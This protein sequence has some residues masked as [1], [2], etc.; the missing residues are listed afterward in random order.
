M[1]AGLASGA[2][3]AGYRIE[4]IVGR[5]G[6]G[7][8]Y[9]A[10]DLSLERPVALKLIAPELA[11][12]DQFRRR[13]LKEPKLAAALDHPNVVP[14]YEAGEHDGQ[15]YLAMR[16]V[17]GSDMRTLLRADGDLAPERALDILAQVASA[18]DAAHRRGL[19]HRDVKPA[20]VLIDED[21]HVYLTDFGVTKQLGGDSTESGQLVGTL[22]YLAPEQIRGEDVD[23]RADLY[24]LACVLYQCLAGHAPFHRETEAETLWAHM[25][26]RP[27]PLAEH[28]DLD[29]VIEKALAKDREDRHATCA[30][31]IEDA[32]ATLT[33]PRVPP[34][35]L[36]RRHAILAAGLLVLAATAVA[37]LLATRDGGSPRP[38]PP[39]P[40][41]GNGLARIG[42]DGSR[43]A[44]FT[45]AGTPPSN[46]AVGEGSVW[47]L[48][49][50]DETVSRVDPRT[51]EVIR[52]FEPRGRPTDI[53]AGAGALWIGT[54]PGHT[55]RVSRVDPATMRE[56]HTE[57]MPA[58]EG[59]VSEGFPMIAV[60][61]GAVWAIN[62]DATVSRL[63]ARTGRRVAT[64]AAPPTGARTIAAGDG[65]VWVLGWENALTRIDP[66]TNRLGDP[67]ELGSNRLFGIAVGAGAAWATSEEGVLWRVDP[68]VERTID[69]GAGVRHVAFGD[70]AVWAANWN[71]GTLSRVDPA[72][73]A[74]TRVP[75]GAAQALAAGAGSAWVSVAG[76]SRNGV[77]PASVCGEVVAGGRTP[78]VLV[79]TDMPLKEEISGP[80]AIADAVRF[81]IRD[82][83][84][85]AGRYAVGYHSCDDS[86]AQAGGVELR[87]C[88]ANANAFASADRLV[89]VIGPL[90]SFCAQYEIPILNRAR[91]GPLALV[92]PTT[93]HPNLTRGG[94]LALPPPFGYRGE[95]DVYYPTGERNFFRV[96]ARG[97]LA[98]V[99]LAELASSLGLRSVYLLDDAPDGFGHVL[100]TDGFAR[101]APSLGVGVAGHARIDPEAPSFA[102]LADRVARSGADGVVV[103][104]HLGFGGGRLLEALRARLGSE[105]TLMTGDGYAPVTRVR[106]EAGRAADDLYIALPY[107]LPAASGVTPAARR[108]TREFGAA[109][110]EDGALMA[111]QAA[112]TVLAAIARSDGTRAS[113]LRELQATRNTGGILGP[114]TFDRYGD[115]TPARFTVLRV[116][117]EA[118][119]GG[120][121]S[122][123]KGA[124]VDRVI[125]VPTGEE[126]Q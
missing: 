55:S 53:A 31:L 102:P 16:F 65:G 124:V 2:T 80:R 105:V 93:T 58:G 82:H 109:A 68:P 9:R 54:G 103:G 24:A 33:R 43:I 34:R 42:S 64:I 84:F 63:D 30:E 78:D 107:L 96:A 21:G 121:G 75:V 70:G 44:S 5:G 94:P 77:L 73:D 119:A 91:G 86:T 104:D 3:F 27:P 57:R 49:T 117:D 125:T 4:S 85:R 51:G 46:I 28:P 114:F 115:L 79:A 74:V 69:I 56:T 18:L 25:Q 22:D 14:I 6:M 36:H 126:T 111:A 10:T 116:T 71:D 60:G 76:G 41:V 62:P 81:V 95:P 100:F 72:T 90:Y 89:T 38:P 17:D 101:A 83:D 40:P 122:G 1:S 97:D 47:V 106:A 11:Q 13:F 61:A 120:R 35:L 113:V 118:P 52:T 88:A 29:P 99:A 98:G 87:K 32:R 20:N 112:E 15:L 8:V 59:P 12:D 37:V 66:S 92:G 23:G 123:I 48:N 110:D 50:E 7:V 45:P 108:F 26:E 39:A 67:L 19:V